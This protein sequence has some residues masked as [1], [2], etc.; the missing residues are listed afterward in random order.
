MGCACSKLNK[1]VNSRSPVKVRS[2]LPATAAAEQSFSEEAN[3]N[4]AMEQ[5]LFF[6][7]A[8]FLAFITAAID[9]CL[10]PIMTS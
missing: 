10:Y 5:V 2:A 9:K 4:V 6:R 1:S 7:A 3:Y 8:R